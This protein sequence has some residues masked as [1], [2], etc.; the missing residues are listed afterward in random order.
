MTNKQTE[1]I[2]KRIWELADKPIQELRINLA[3]FTSADMPTKIEVAI[4]THGMSRGA[5]IDAIIREEF[6]NELKE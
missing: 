4:A 5:L 3:G 6:D 2:L 1:E